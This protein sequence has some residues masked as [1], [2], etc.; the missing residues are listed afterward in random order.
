MKKSNRLVEFK[1]SDIKE[2]LKSFKTKRYLNPVVWENKDKIRQNIRMQLLDIA[3]DLWDDLELNFN[4]SDIILTGSLANYNWSSYS[5]FDL[6]ILLDFEKVD[7]NVQ[8]VKKY[9][10]EV[11]A[12]WNLKH[13]ITIFDYDVEIYLQDIN[14]PHQ[15]T[16]I[17]SLLNDNW[18]VVSSPF[19]VNLDDSSI[20][21]KSEGYMKEVDDIEKDFNSDSYEEIKSRIK[22]VWDKIKKGRQAG[23]ESGGEMSVENLVFKLLRRNGY[24]EKLVDMKL[25]AY[26]KYRTIK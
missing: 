3:N 14:E 11:K 9:M 19:H 16:G 21:L 26:D 2:P 13:N 18:K 12:N 23:L 6:H 7:K 20:A 4:Y 24:I 10:D 17:Y 25:Q 5:D 1:E 22:R 8:L 15:S